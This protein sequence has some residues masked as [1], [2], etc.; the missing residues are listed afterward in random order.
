MTT[1]NCP[2]G[3]NITEHYWEHLGTSGPLS[4]IPARNWRQWGGGAVVGGL[5]AGGVVTSHAPGKA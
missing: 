1:T 3:V 2:T 4:H 5:V